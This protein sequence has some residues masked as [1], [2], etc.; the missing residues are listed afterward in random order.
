MELIK[1]EKLAAKREEEAA[2]LLRKQEAEKKAKDNL[3]DQNVTSFVKKIQAAIKNSTSYL[4]IPS[5]GELEE[6]YDT[7]L[8]IPVDDLE[9]IQKE[10]LLS[11]DRREGRVSDSKKIILH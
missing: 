6:M 11:K 3:D 7:F 9:P 2:A 5:V 4:M 8:S 10:F 1:H